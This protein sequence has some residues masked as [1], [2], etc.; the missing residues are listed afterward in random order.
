MNVIGDQTAQRIHHGGR[1]GI[2]VD[3]L[4]SSLTSQWIGSRGCGGHNSNKV[5]TPIHWFVTSRG[6]HNCKI[7][8]HLRMLPDREMTT[9]SV[10]LSWGSLNGVDNRPIASFRE[11]I[12][13]WIQIN[14]PPWW[15][16]ELVMSLLSN[17]LIKLKHSEFRQRAWQA[18]ESKEK[19]P[20][21]SSW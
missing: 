21:H 9:Y 20:S 18:S 19:I 6:D 4:T 2:L 14:S 10:L 13:K 12:V 7:I 17:K 1:S 3:H 15:V 5:L 11:W 16:Y 8:C